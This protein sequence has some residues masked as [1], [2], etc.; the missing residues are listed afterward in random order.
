MRYVK[1]GI[2]AAVVMAVAACGPSRVGGVT[3][4]EAA[5]D[6]PSGDGE[7]QEQGRQVAGQP[8]GGLMGESSLAEELSSIAAAGPEILP[9]YAMYVAITDES[10]AIQIQVPREWADTEDRPVASARGRALA[11][12]RAAVDLQSFEQDWTTP[13]VIVDGTSQLIPGDSE[14]TLLDEVVQPLSAACV[15]QGRRPYPSRSYTVALDIY[16]SCGGSGAAYVVIGAAPPN[17]SWVMRLRLK[18]VSGRDLEALDRIVQSVR[19]T[20]GV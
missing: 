4:T 11:S 9:G 19:V 7:A 13:G 17:R 20:G 2:I 15:Y 3:P 10:Y 12:V 8:S 6:P 5:P 16:T 1:H 14:V 18:V